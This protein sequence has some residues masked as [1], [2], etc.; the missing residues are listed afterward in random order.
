MQYYDAVGAGCRLCANKG[1]MGWRERHGPGR[2]LLCDTPLITSAHAG[3]KH[4]NA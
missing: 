2:Q 4:R 1:T 3:K